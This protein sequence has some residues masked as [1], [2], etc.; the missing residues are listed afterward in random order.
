MTDRTGAIQ[1]E[2]K[3]MAG[4]RYGLLRQPDREWE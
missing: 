1:L 4:G 3:G 2:L